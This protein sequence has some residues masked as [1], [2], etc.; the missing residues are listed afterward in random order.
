MSGAA[1]T[2]GSLVRSSQATEYKVSKLER[3]TPLKLA[4]GYSGTLT[5]MFIGPLPNA[6][7]GSI[8]VNCLRVMSID[9]NG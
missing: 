1:T 4:G 7:P 3:T 6:L 2:C 8:L 9:N 5:N